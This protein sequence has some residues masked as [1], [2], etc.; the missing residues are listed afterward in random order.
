[1]KKTTTLR[2]LLAT[3]AIASVNASYAQ[4][5]SATP[6]YP[7]GVFRSAAT[8]AQY[9]KNGPSLAA[10]LV[11][12]AKAL[13]AWQA[14]PAAQLEPVTLHATVTAKNRGGS[15]ELRIRNFHYIGDCGYKHG[16]QD[17]GVET[18]T[19]ARGVFASDIAN[20]IL[21][22]AALQGIG[23]D[24]LYIDIQGQPDKTP[25]NRVN[26]TRNF[27]YTVRI[28]SKATD[29]QL[30]QLVVAAEQ[31]SPTVNLIKRAVTPQ[32][33][34]DYKQTPRERTVGGKT[35]AGLREYIHGKRQALLAYYNPDSLKAQPA[36]K[37]AEPAPQPYVKVLPNGLRQLNVPTGGAWYIIN[38]DN[39]EY[40]GGA[41]SAQTSLENTLGV[42]G[43]C[44]T[45]ISEIQA[46]KLDLDVDSLQ[47]T[48]A[49]D[50]DPRAGRKG[51]ENVP[52]WPQNVR[53][54][55]HV[56]TPETLET[57]K[58]WID[59]VE[60]ICPMYNVFK[61]TQTFEHKIVRL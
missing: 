16:G 19:T 3:L 1:M 18:Q 25:T 35:L 14:I 22:Q 9:A 58:R 27:L 32:L 44:I 38:H 12:R 61:D 6:D 54:T 47:L 34:I 55:I 29:A 30:E 10:H 15:R 20:A 13:K 8:R 28:A 33:S 43:T 31:H 4:A 59:S 7:F 60:K 41:N 50:I 24:S 52:F 51:Y 11:Q 2:T 45:H 56:Q 40:L 48:V 42:L 46:A 36:P 37:A 21:D 57:V 26:Y 39:P 49:A 53:Y 23:I 5:Q 17:T